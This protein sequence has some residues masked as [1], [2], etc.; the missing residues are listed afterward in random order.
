MVRI[1][2]AEYQVYRI[3]HRCHSTNFAFI[4]ASVFVSLYGVEAERYVSTRANKDVSGYKQGWQP[5]WARFLCPPFIP[6]WEMV[7]KQKS[8]P[9]K[10]SL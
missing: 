8:L 10:F 2:R 3:S 6:R 1:F 9:A 5:G 4:P 7:D